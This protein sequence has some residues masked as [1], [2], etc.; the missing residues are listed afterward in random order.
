[1]LS[2]SCTSLP[3]PPAPW[4]LRFIKCGVLTL[5]V[6]VVTLLQ[7]LPAHGDREVPGLLFGGG[8]A[9]RQDKP[10]ELDPALPRGTEIRF[11][12]RPE[13]ES[14]ACSWRRPVCVHGSEGVGLQ[15][16]LEL[17][18]SA[19][20][21]LISV[22]QLPAPLADGTLGGGPELDWYLDDEQT[23]LRVFPD[24]ARL[25]RDQSSAFCSSAP[26]QI[27]AQSAA[28]CVAEA[29]SY[30]L[31]AAETPALREGYGGFAS[32]LIGA[33]EAD[34]FEFVDQAQQQPEVAL[35]RRDH[36][37]LDA[38]AAL[39]FAYVEEALGS[40]QAGV[41]PTAL[42]SLSRGSTEA[43]SWDW[44]N[45]PDSFDVLRRAFDEDA[46]RY[47]DFMVQFAASRA[48]LGDRDDGT[49][50]PGLAWLGDAGRV[51]FDWSL[52]YSS[53]PRNVASPRPLEPMGAS[54]VWLELDGV[55][56]GARLAFRAQWEEP[57]RFKWLVIA[58][59]HEGREMT[60]WDVPYL[61]RGTKVEKTLMNFEAAAGLMFIAMN[62]GGVDLLHPFDPD[63]E[64]WEKHGYTLYITELPN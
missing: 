26:S 39:W 44:N 64:P 16:P 22:L 9:E 36:S 13:A 60:R 8:M 62:L 28:R 19:Y 15:R 42:L 3:T 53:L 51:R 6:G 23:E 58:V 38:A 54:Y 14:S 1:M 63:Y 29:L 33:S 59:D 7:S 45:E 61:E 21:R 57:V 2:K 56:L 5:G 52:R 46:Q 25:T 31:D 17:M 41:V 27:S 47:A 32:W 11:F 20:E 43:G 48:F 35:M 18:V 40:A 34:D 12:Q 10:V 24:P 49:H 50:A 55:P 37:K 30:A 4:R